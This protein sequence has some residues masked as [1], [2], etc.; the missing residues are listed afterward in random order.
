MSKRVRSRNAAQPGPPSTRPRQ[1]AVAA[2]ALI[3]GAVAAWAFWPDPRPRQ[4]EYLDATACLLTDEKGVT[5]KGAAPIWSAMQDASVS[6]LVR[7]QYL[8][9]NG[10]QTADNARAYVASLAGGKCGVVIAVGTAQVDAV[11]ATAQTFPA[12]RFVT[13]G[14]GTPSANVSVVEASDA[15]TAIGQRV[16]ALAD[17]N[18]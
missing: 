4:R 1:F 3:L 15:A 6:S 12:A 11:T 18:S 14:G 2:L 16:S 10:P 9:V 13:V 17:E 5:G 7:V 8:P